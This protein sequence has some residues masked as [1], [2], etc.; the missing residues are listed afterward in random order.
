MT[1]K[2]IVKKDNTEAI[3]K[4][5]R[6]LVSKQVLIGIPGGNDHREGDTA[7]NALVGYVQEHGSPAQNID[8]RS[9]LRPGVKKAEEKITKHLKAAAKEALKGHFQN[10]EKS[11]HSVG[12]EAVK[13]VKNELT[14][15]DHKALSDKTIAARKRRGRTGIRPLVDTEKLRLSIKYVIRD[16]K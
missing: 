1:A 10:V 16:K 15:G 2:V 4:S 3:F 8:A 7:G 11:F 9:F 5:V 6:D 13:S 14:N 12:A